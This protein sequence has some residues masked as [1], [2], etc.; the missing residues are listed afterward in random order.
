MTLEQRLLNVFKQVRKP[1]AHALPPI[2]VIGGVGMALAIAS[3]SSS[4]GIDL[5]IYPDS[6]KPS[7]EIIND[8]VT[9]DIINE[10]DAL[11]RI[12]DVLGNTI[13]KHVKEIMSRGY[14]ERLDSKDFFHGHLRVADPAVCESPKS[15]DDYPMLNFPKNMDKN[16]WLKLFLNADPHFIYH[17]REKLI[18]QAPYTGP[19]RS[20]IGTIDGKVYPLKSE[21]GYFKI[22]G[23]VRENKPFEFN[24]QKHDG[25][26]FGVEDTKVRLENNTFGKLVSPQF[27]ILPDYNGRYELNNGQ[28]FDVFY[29]IRGRWQEKLSSTNNQ[30]LEK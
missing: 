20:L 18:T 22:Y 19:P 10:T 15:V 9:G 21:D 1:V 16:E 6:S 30:E 12:D 5:T 25:M 17:T 4:V 23:T 7:R 8:L 24:G 11:Y 13:A 3:C 2:L 14:A 26:C 27:Y 29:Q 28:R